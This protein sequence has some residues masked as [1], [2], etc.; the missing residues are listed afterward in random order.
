MSDI[1]IMKNLH[2]INNL[3]EKFSSLYFW[4]VFLSYNK[5]ELFSSSIKKKVSIL[6]INSYLLI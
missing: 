1:I 6:E 2:T 3:I 4:N 5:I